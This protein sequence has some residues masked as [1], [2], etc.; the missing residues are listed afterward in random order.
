MSDKTVY[1]VHHTDYYSATRSFNVIADSHEQAELIAADLAMEVEQT[2]KEFNES[3]EPFHSCDS[4]VHTEEADDQDDELTPI[5][6]EAVETIEARNSR[7]NIGSNFHGNTQ[8]P[9]LLRVAY[10]QHLRE[11]DSRC[12]IT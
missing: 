7:Y 6:L 12:E 4:E 1:T 8:P 9:C 3:L 10:E 5:P 2:E 11:G